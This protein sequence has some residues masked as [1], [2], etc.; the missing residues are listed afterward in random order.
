MDE[1]D[2]RILL[3]GLMITFSIMVSS[4]VAL[5]GDLTQITTDSGDQIDSDI[6]GSWITYTATPYGNKDIMTYNLIS[7]Q[8]TNINSG[9]STDQYL[10]Q[11]DGTKIVFTSIGANGSDNYLYDITTSSTTPLS[12]G[13]LNG[14]QRLREIM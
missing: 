6:S 10:S 5:E 13:V 7:K 12:S 1:T 4:V 8:E 9:T 2:H 3:I 14:V 11:I